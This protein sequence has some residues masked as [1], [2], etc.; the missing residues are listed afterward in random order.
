[1]G[2][3]AKYNLSDVKKAIAGLNKEVETLFVEA[4]ENAVDVAVSKGQYQN[5]THNLRSSIGYALAQNG[6]IIKEG[7]FKKGSGQGENM[8]KV[9]FST[10]EGK[11]VNFW[12]KGPSGDGSVGSEKGRELAENIAT[13]SRDRYALAVVAAMPY[14]QYVND[15][16][17]NVMDNAE[18]E[19]RNTFKIR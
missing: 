2:L 6:A 18:I 8:Q 4:G 19:L 3:S 5:R 17:F 16:G 13:S 15:M 12:A 7:G 9:S 14:A 11:N 10:K 1:M